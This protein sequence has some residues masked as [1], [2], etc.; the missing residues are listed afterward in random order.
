[1]A[2]EAKQPACRPVSKKK[3]QKCVVECV[4]LL[5]RVLFITINLLT[6][7]NFQLR[8]L[9]YGIASSFWRSTVSFN[10]FTLFHSIFSICEAMTRENSA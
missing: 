8:F 4:I 3:H 6:L 10:V 2:R 7:K 5:L 9:F 1:M